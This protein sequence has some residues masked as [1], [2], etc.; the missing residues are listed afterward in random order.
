[1][2]IVE[3]P[4]ER[5][6]DIEHLWNH[7]NQYHNDKSSH[8][9]DYSE[10][11]DFLN[12]RKTLLARDKLAIF[13]AVDEGKMI[14]Y[15]ISSIEGGLGEIDSMYVMKEYRNNGTGTKLASHAMAWLQRNSPI[16]INIYVAEGNESIIPFYERS[17]FLKKYYVLQQKNS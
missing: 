4:K 10:K 17:G 13:V 2:E 5:L 7:L 14:G 12:S 9:N 8:F 16:E 15:C 1:M 11:H 3:I 6:G